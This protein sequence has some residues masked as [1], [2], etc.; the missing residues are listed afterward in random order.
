MNHPLNKAEVLFWIFFYKVW[1]YLFEL[2][3]NLIIHLEIYLLHSFFREIE[4]EK[5]RVVT[6]IDKCVWRYSRKVIKGSSDF[7][8]QLAYF[9]EHFIIRIIFY[10]ICNTSNQEKYK[11]H[12]ILFREKSPYHETDDD[13]ERYDIPETSSVFYIRKIPGIYV[14]IFHKFFYKER[15]LSIMSFTMNQASD[16]IAKPPRAISIVFLHLVLSCWREPKRSWYAQIMTNIT[17]IVPAI[18]MR[19]FVAETIILGMLSRLTFPF[20]R[21]L[22]LMLSQKIPESHSAKLCIIE[23]WATMRINIYFILVFM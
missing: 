8:S 14:F 13:R 2:C 11:T 21:S 4:P 5:Y 12:P 6:I 20:L 18:P 22:A 23:A 9:N 7:D 1:K 19:K 3:C 17:A 10:E 16:A 15:K